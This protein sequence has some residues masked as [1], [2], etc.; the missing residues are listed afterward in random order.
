VSGTGIDIATETVAPSPE[1]APPPGGEAPAPTPASADTA[2]PGEPQPEQ[3]KR[4]RK[5]EKRI[6][7]LTQKVDSLSEQVGYWRG[8]AEAHARQPGQQPSN[9]GEP[10][11]ERKQP[12]SRNSAADEAAAELGRS[13]FARLEEGGK[14][15]ED[16][17]EVMETITQPNFPI[18]ETI[19]DYLA[20][21]DN[22]AQLAQWMSENRTEVRRIASLSPAVATR[23]LEKQD[24]KLAKPPGKKTTQ[25][26]PPVPTVGGRSTAEFDPEK[27]SMDEYAAHW[28][29]R[30]AKRG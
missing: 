28:K 22:P 16:F 2:V 12:A 14:E 6:S 4:D 20:I 30:Q 19:R 13:I 27:A 9:E 10:T 1:V 24:A 15:I 25:A 21:A 18:N 3:G 7:R 5:V 29:E 23:A 26:P 8:I 11:A 17:D